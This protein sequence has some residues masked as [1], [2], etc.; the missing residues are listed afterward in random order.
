MR[1][2]VGNTM[3]FLWLHITLS[4]SKKI[5]GESSSLAAERE[6]SILRLY[7]VIATGEHTQFVKSHH[8]VSRA[9]SH[10]LCQAEARASFVNS[11][12]SEIT[13]ML[14]G[15]LLCV[16]GMDW[17]WRNEKPSLPPPAYNNIQTWNYHPT[18]VDVTEHFNIIFSLGSCH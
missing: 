2:R 8:H 16:N 3:A 12:E 7:A 17:M 13:M 15:A 4:S 10:R 5:D 6:A 14:G 11:L 1:R 9:I 18:I